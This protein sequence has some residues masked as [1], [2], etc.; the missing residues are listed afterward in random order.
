MFDDDQHYG[1]IVSKHVYAGA[2]RA[3]EVLSLIDCISVGVGRIQRNFEPMRK[4]VEVW[5]QSELTDVAAKLVTYE[6]FVEGELEA[7]KT[8]LHGRCLISI[9]SGTARRSPDLWTALPR[10]RRR[11]GADP[12]S[13]RSHFHLDNRTISRLQTAHSRCRQRQNRNRAVG[14]SEP[15]TVRFADNPITGSH[16]P[17]CTM[18][19]RT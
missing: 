11:T 3:L 8:H 14:L 2:C 10:R 19:E 1:N 4:Q 5:Q 18:I 15:L 17:A 16:F 12:V 13:A 9:S 6:A 7:P